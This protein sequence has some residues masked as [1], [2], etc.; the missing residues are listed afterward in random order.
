MRFLI[1]LSVAT[2]FAV[3]LLAGCNSTQS[4]NRSANKSTA[5]STPTAATTPAV[6][7]V[8]AAT[9]K[10]GVRRITPAELQAAIEKGE[11]VVVDVRNQANYQKGHI[12]DA[13]LIPADQIAARAD[14]LPRDKMI[15]TYCA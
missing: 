6:G 8:A 13:R 11:A 10:D 7:P 3:T 15:V 5:R 1:S 2:V 4:E 9:P 12:K 14:E